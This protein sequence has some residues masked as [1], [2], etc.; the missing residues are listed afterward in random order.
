MNDTERVLL[1]IAIATSGSCFDEMTKIK[2]GYSAIRTSF[3]HPVP[4]FLPLT[5]LKTLDMPLEEG[6]IIRCETNRTHQWSISKFIEI[7]SD[8]GGAFGS[9]EYLCQKIGGTETCRIS[10]ESITV[11]RFMSQSLLLCGQE[12]KIYDWCYKA[13]KER[14][15]K[16]GDYYK[17]CGGVEIKP[18]SA[19]VWSRPHVWS[20][21]SKGKQ[22]ETL[23]AVPK[24][25]IIP[26]DKKTRLK[27]IIAEMK[28]QGFAKK[29]EYSKVEQTE[30]M[31]G[32]CKI[33]KKD[34]NF[35]LGIA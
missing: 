10:N 12:K 27:D 29:Y 9:I 6:D 2:G 16:D 11:L 31:G 1:N 4:Q 5:T 21:V 3:G 25:F 20:Q 14:Y 8:S 17:R 32:C 26:W 18:D 7:L 33:T 22:G 15:N 13:F 28:K 19:I 23:Y 35:A 34:I 30:G 24:Q